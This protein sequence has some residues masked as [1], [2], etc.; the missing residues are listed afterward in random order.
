MIFRIKC[1][2]KK[3]AIDCGPYGLNVKA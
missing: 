1:L 3:L 2:I